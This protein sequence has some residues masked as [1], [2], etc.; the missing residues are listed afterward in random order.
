MTPASWRRSGPR[1]R[2]PS[3]AAADPRRAGCR[4]RGR[5]PATR[6]SPTSSAP[7]GE[8]S[9]SRSPGR[10]SSATRPAHRGEPGRLHPA[11]PSRP[12][13]AWTPGPLDAARRSSRPTSPPTDPPPRRSSTP[14]SASAS[15]SRTF[16]PGSRRRPPTSP[17]SR[18]TARPPGRNTADLDA[19]AAIRPPRRSVSSPPSTS[20][21]WRAGTDNPWYLAPARR[22]AVSRA[23]GWI[24]PIVVAGGRIVGTWDAKAGPIA[25]EL[26]AEDETAVSRAA[27]TAEA[28]R[29]ASSRSVAPGAAAGDLARRRFVLPSPSSIRRMGRTPR[30]GRSLSG[31]RRFGRAGHPRLARRRSRVARRRHPPPGV[32]HAIRPHSLA[33]NPTHPPACPRRRPDPDRDL[34]REHPRGVGYQREA[35]ACAGRGARRPARQPRSTAR[36]P[37]PR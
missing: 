37:R 7:A 19:L 4:R 32:P 11:G 31:D 30:C 28:A 17:A 33:A 5:R 25:V 24:A 10:A 9:S 18:S 20:S 36:S 15:G 8:A 22:P 27:L 26:F 16:A 6:P 21:S 29:V 3:R 35:R 23:A 14:G 1:S 2:S 12:G 34:G 13:L